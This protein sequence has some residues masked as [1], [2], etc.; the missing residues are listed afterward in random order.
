MLMNV[1]DGGLDKEKGRGV[2]PGPG[3]QSGSRFINGKSLGVGAAPTAQGLLAE[4]FEET[5]VEYGQLR[6]RWLQILRDYKRCVQISFA[7]DVNMCL[8]WV[9]A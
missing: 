1:P 5:A 7:P 2:L 6:R 8:N 4:E 9:L 3:A